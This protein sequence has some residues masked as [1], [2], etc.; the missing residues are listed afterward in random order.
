MRTCL[1]TE[2]LHEV[3]PDALRLG[4]LSGA[5]DDPRKEVQQE[6]LCFLHFLIMEF[7]A[8][9]HVSTFTRVSC[10]VMLLRVR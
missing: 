3:G 10:C 5:E 1:Q 6:V 9:K 2:I 4:L 7:V 8:G